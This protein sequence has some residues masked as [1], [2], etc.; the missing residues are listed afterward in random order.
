MAPQRFS[1]ST[2]LLLFQEQFWHLGC[3]TSVAPTLA[4]L[5][6][7]FAPLAQWVGKA[8]ETTSSTVS[9]VSG[10]VQS[11]TTT[12]IRK[13]VDDIKTLANVGDC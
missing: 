10:T 11:V 13:V 9:T 5:A 2:E 12:S 8:A 1:C 7:P 4:P 6:H 3:P